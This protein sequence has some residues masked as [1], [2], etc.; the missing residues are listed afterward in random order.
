MGETSIL[1]CGLNVCSPSWQ[2][3]YG[4]DSSHSHQGRSGNREREG[5]LAY[6]LWGPPFPLS[7]VPL[8]LVR[9][10]FHNVPTQCYQ[11]GTKCSIP[12]ANEGMFRIRAI[13]GRFHENFKSTNKCSAN[14]F[15]TVWPEC[16]GKGGHMKLECR[17]RNRIMW[18]KG[19]RDTSESM[20]QKSS[21]CRM[22]MSFLP[23]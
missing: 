11:L 8:P 7:N 20:L 14:Q 19:T 9:P 22:T 15:S 3:G 1:T 2:K 12:W 23:A 17:L 4:C 5:R 10:H 16:K 21:Q 6:E 18:P 13:I